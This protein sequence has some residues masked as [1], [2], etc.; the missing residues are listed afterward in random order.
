MRERG[1]EGGRERDEGSNGRG[2]GLKKLYPMMIC[3]HDNVTLLFCMTLCVCMC[4]YVCVCVCMCVSAFIHLSQRYICRGY[5]H[6]GGNPI[7][8]FKS[9]K[10]EGI[11]MFS[12]F[13]RLLSAAGSIGAAHVHVPCAGCNI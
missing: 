9:L 1:G 13:P 3:L 11:L 12:Q 7:K 5:I 10:L 2:K 8:F 6:V 4:V